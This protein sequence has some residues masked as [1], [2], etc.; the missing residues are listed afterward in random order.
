[1]KISK[2]TTLLALAVAATFAACGENGI[3]DA[4]GI[5]LDRDEIEF[6]STG[7]EQIVTLESQ[8]QWSVGQLPDWISVDVENPFRAVVR[9]GKNT[10]TEDRS[11]QIEFKNGADRAVLQIKQAA[12]SHEFSWI[13]LTNGVEYVSNSFAGDNHTFAAELMFIS[14]TTLDKIHVGKVIDRNPCPDQNRPWLEGFHRLP[15]AAWTDAAGV[16]S[17]NFV[18]SIEAQAEYAQKIIA[19]KPTQS[20][21]FFVNKAAKRYT[22]RRELYLAGMSNFG[23]ELDKAVSGKSYREQEMT[24]KNGLIFSFTDSRFQIG[25]DVPA[26]LIEEELKLENYPDFKL[27]YIHTVTYGRWGLLIVETDRELTAVQAA[28][29]AV[30]NGHTPT[31]EQAEILGEIKAYHIHGH[32]G[33]LQTEQDGSGK[34]IITSYLDQLLYDTND[35][36]PLRY[37]ACDYFDHGVTEVKFI[38]AVPVK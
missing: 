26:Q 38:V 14:P 23:V 31:A 11:A 32:K 36:Y 21:Y 5:K 29:N 35:I 24:C 6:K 28:V 33:R 4:R 34:E 17:T 13:K 8:T 20:T 7:G 16:L 18:P 12:E 25:I 9:A 10:K 1:M 30:F 15:V 19:S 22:S 2:L 3:D 27:S 37:E